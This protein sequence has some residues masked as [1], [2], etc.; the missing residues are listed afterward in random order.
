M[1]DLG[2]D[3]VK[4]EGFMNMNRNERSLALNL[5]NKAGREPLKGRAGT[6]RTTHHG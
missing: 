2:A 1:G 5:K 4:I 3:V 6:R